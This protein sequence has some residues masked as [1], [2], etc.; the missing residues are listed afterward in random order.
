MSTIHPSYPSAQDIDLWCE[1]LYNDAINCKVEVKILEESIYS[2]QLGRFNAMD[3]NRYIEFTLDDGQQFYALWQPT[4]SSRAPLAVHTPGY[5]AE[6]HE[7][8]ELVSQGFHVLH[9]EPM[10]YCTPEGRQE[11]L[12]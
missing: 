1:Q 2:P 10:G 8:P 11:H 12:Y 3:V 6:I 5:G 9:V 4:F 7:H